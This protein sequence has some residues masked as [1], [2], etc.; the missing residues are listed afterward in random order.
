MPDAF[1]SG[2]ETIGLDDLLAPLQAYLGGI[3]EQ[4]SAI[5]KRIDMLGE[6][7]NWLV[8]NTAQAFAAIQQMSSSGMMGKLLAGMKGEKSE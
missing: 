8:Q 3:Q 1:S 7:S 6:Q 2:E 4:L 5:N